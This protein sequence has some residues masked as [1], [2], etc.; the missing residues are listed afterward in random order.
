LLF[1]FEITKDLAGRNSNNNTSQNRAGHNFAGVN[2]TDSYLMASHQK[3]VGHGSS[4]GHNGMNGSGTTH[5]QLS[6]SPQALLPMHSNDTA[7]APMN[8]EMNS[9]RVAASPVLT[10]S[11]PYLRPSWY[12][13]HH[14]WY[15]CHTLLIVDIRV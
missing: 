9:V 1:K 3:Q 6:L 14:R 8:D 13:I 5:Q 2:K 7:L 15:V 12:T 10:A 4:D 11:T